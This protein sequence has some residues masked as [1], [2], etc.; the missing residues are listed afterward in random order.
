MAN[1]LKNAKIAQMT[2]NIKKFDDYIQNMDFSY[3][4]DEEQLALQVSN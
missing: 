4:L 2:N 1:K 3:H